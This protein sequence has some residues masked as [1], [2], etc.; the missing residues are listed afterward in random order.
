MRINTLHWELRVIHR[1]VYNKVRFSY[2]CYDFRP[3]IPQDVISD[4]QK[5]KEDRVN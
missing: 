4:L 2:L 3:L 1:G 5:N